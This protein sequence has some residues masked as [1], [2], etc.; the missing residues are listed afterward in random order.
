M[1]NEARGAT[2]EDND[3]LHLLSKQEF[4]DRTRHL[5][6]DIDDQEFDRLWQE[7]QTKKH[8]KSLN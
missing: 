6:P 7:F 3:P 2:G 1:N 8:I 4:R 5:C